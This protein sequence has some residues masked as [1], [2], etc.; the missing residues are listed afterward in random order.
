MFNNLS[1]KRTC[2]T[3]LVCAST[4]VLLSACGGGGDDACGEKSQVFGIE[5]DA[6]S[7]SLPVGK[8]ATLRSTVT[9]ESC[10]PDMTFIV[11]DGTL[12]RGMSLDSGNVAG[13]PTTAGT[14]KFQIG[15]EA[16]G[17]YQPLLAFIAPRSSQI[18]VTVTP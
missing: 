12:P 15:I 18:T 4:V 6:K 16:V 10:R 7:V 13:T 5:F 11:R 8:P 9:P 14:Y 1:T 3:A 2:M 17:G